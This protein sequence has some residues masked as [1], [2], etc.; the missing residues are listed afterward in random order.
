MAAAKFTVPTE[1]GAAPPG[2]SYAQAAKRKTLPSHPTSQLSNTSHEAGETQKDI[3]LAKS[4]TSWAE[5]TEA[6]LEPPKKDSA[7]EVVTSDT[8]TVTK[9]RLQP[10][11][12]PSESQ[13][14][15][16]SATS[17]PEFG[18]SS[19]STLAEKEETSSLPNTSSESTWENKSQASNSAEK[20]THN[21]KETSIKRDDIVKEDAPLKDAPPP[22]VN[23][24]QQRAKEQQAARASV[25]PSPAKTIGPAHTAAEPSNKAKNVAAKDGTRPDARRKARSASAGR[26]SSSVVQSKDRKRSVDAGV[27][28]RDEGKAVHNRRASRLDNEVERSSARKNSSKDALLEQEEGTGS[29]EPPSVNDETS[30]PA[31]GANATDEKQGKSQEKEEKERTPSSNSKLHGKQEWVQIQIPPANYLFDTPLP[32]TNSRRGG[33]GGSR[34]GR[35]NGGRGASHTLHEFTKGEKSAGGENLAAN[36]E[37]SNKSSKRDKLESDQVQ[38]GGQNP[39]S[40][41]STSK[42]NSE[43]QSSKGLFSGTA[44][45]AKSNAQSGI[46]SGNKEAQAMKESQPSYNHQSRPSGAPKWRQTQRNGDPENDRRRESETDVKRGS[47]RFSNATQIEGT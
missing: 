4:S 2:V 5:E 15:A 25:Q 42:E 28:N 1:G 11:Q 29:P 44:A 35:D 23:I 47:R 40:R 12:T 45:T 26:E 46:E 38:T 33:R 16:V 18:I 41:T 9:E 7:H 31:M 14:T 6:S 17:T 39:T 20:S 21:P 22:S 34:G 36:T 19:T 10:S 24:W 37:A 8:S 13:A 3:T 27:K 43:F 30:W 32:S